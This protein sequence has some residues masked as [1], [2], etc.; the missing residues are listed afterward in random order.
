MSR[1]EIIAIVKKISYICIFVIFCKFVGIMRYINALNKIDGLGCKK[2]KQLMNFFNSSE[3]AWQADFSS[4]VKSGVGEAVAEKIV[5]QRPN[6]N[7]DEEWARLEKENILAFSI[8]DEEYPVL[9]KQIPDSPYIIYMKGN[10]DCLNL[11]L[12]A[13]VGSRKL[14]EYGS[15]VARIFARDLANNGICVVSG[16]AF[17]VDAAAHRGALDAKG[18]T[19]AVLGNS[20]DTESIYPR[21]NFQLAE[22]IIENGGLI[23]S[24]FPVAT[25]AANWT[26]PARN[27]IMAGMSLGTLVVEAAE[28]SGSLITAN[29]ALDYNREVFAVPGPIFSPQSA[30]THML[31]KSS[32]AK[33]VSCAAD[34]M[35]E[36][37]IEQDMKPTAEK[38]NL[39]LTE[40][41]KNI[42]STLS[43]E[44]IYIDRITKLTKLE[45]ATVSGTLA[46][47]EIKGLVKNVGG[48]QYIKC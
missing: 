23:I 7:P 44:K 39:E 38:M 12:V 40:E 16:L 20:L 17:G 34:I 46:M 2:L 47:L 19:I 35:S 28:K 31:I 3:S 10:L 18:K 9:L 42:L 8:Q 48:Q 5:A 26:F 41:E 25:Q 15:R 14:T 36:L 22:E 45:T 32:G 13:I 29:L 11:P 1:V 33:L 6:I 24:E 37:K 27:R 21:S 30:G 4:L 43:H